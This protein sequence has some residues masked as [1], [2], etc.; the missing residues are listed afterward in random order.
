M[1]RNALSA[2]WV[3]GWVPTAWTG[4]TF[5]PLSYPTLF[6]ILYLETLSPPI[7][8]PTLGR[9]CAG[10]PESSQEARCLRLLEMV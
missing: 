2:S 7:P 4:L 6:P 8:V 5:Q 9:P 3:L 10:S 1:E